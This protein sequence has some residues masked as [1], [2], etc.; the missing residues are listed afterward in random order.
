M[1]ENI[2]PYSPPCSFTALWVRSAI[3][4]I[5]KPQRFV[6]DGYGLYILFNFKYI[7][8]IWV[9]IASFL[10]TCLSYFTSASSMGR[11]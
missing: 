5:D 11:T 1:P 2:V 9:P 4:S 3:Q 7:S 8:G 10:S 6:I